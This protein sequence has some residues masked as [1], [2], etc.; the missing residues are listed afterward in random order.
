MRIILS[1]GVKYWNKHQ[2]ERLCDELNNS[3]Y[4]PSWVSRDPNKGNF[5][6]A[7]VCSN[8]LPLSRVQWALGGFRGWLILQNW[9]RV[10]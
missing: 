8:I 1:R 5:I 7:A 6:L 2:G 3:G 10:V 9:T 4:F